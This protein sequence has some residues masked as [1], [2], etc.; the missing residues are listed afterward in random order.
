MDYNEKFSFFVRI[1]LLLEFI[2]NIFNLSLLN[3]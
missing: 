3:K 2:S 1:D